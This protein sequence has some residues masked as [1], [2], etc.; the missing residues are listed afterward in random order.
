MDLK[1]IPPLQYDLNDFQKD[2]LEECLKKK[3]G[4]LSIP[5]GSGKTIIA[6]VL[7][8]LLPNIDDEEKVLVCCSKTLLKS[9]EIE[10]KKFFGEN[11]DNYYYTYYDKNIK[12]SKQ[13]INNVKFVLTTPAVFVKQYTN[14]N[15][16][17]YI[18]NYMQDSRNRIVKN[19]TIPRTHVLSQSLDNNLLYSTNWK[20]L[21]IDEIQ[22]YTNIE[23]KICKALIS[24]STRYRWGTSGTII[25][26]PSKER[27]LGYHLLINEPFFPTNLPETETYL[28]SAK[29][30]G[31]NSTLV[32][33]TENK[34][35]KEP[36]M[37]VN[38]IS[39]SL[40]NQEIDIYK[41]MKRLFERIH[42]II[43]DHKDIAANLAYKIKYERALNRHNVTNQEERDQNDVDLLAA[44]YTVRM[45]SS[46]LLGMIV[47][48]RQSIETP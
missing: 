23:T 30:K 37:N 29:F 44:Q 47:Y 42:D 36:K 48:L 15:I 6:L 24:V 8:L 31:I 32:S 14:Y 19:Y 38:I 16:E 39:H 11:A 1:S 41:M 45:Y 5:M 9:W 4:G 2:I 22:N 34:A 26:E 28:C 25:S 27:I 33:R 20:C 46:G 7:S 43:M 18:V 40:T 21:V 3:N 10:I 13:K 17:E 35:Y 12:N